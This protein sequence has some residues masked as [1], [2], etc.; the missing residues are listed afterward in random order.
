MFITFES[1]EKAL[2]AH[3]D[4]TEYSENELALMSVPSVAYCWRQYSRSLFALPTY[5]SHVNFGFWIR[6]QQ[7]QPMLFE[8]VESVKEAGVV[9]WA[10]VTLHRRA[11]IVLPDYKTSALDV[12]LLFEEEL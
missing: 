9:H 7:I 10:T 2:A 1:M 6:N 4:F 8:L 11:V 3:V 5:I 12:D